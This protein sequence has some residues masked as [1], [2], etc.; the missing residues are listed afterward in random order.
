MMEKSNE[1]FQWIEHDKNKRTFSNL[2]FFK[3]TF[4]YSKPESFD[5]NIQ[6]IDKNKFPKRSTLVIISAL[7]MDLCALFVFLSIRRLEMVEM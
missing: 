2:V 5:T 6:F 3:N 4:R 7:I 1:N